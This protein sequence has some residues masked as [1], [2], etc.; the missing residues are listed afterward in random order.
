[1]NI[2]EI[3]SETLY[4]E[5]SLEIPYDEIDDLINT[6]IKEIIPTVSL[7]GFRK[8]KA[9]I[10]IVKKKY[11]S[12][13]LSDVIEKIVQEKTKNLLEEKKLKPFRQPRVDLK[14]YEKNQPVQIEVKIDLEPKI[15]LKNFKNLKLKKYKIE[16][17]KKT[18]E[19]NYN[20][21]LSS[22]KNYNKLE[23]KRVVKISDKININIETKDSTVPE[24]LKSQKNFPLVTDSEYQVLPELGK[25]LI[26]KKVKTGDKIVLNFDISKIINSKTAKKVDFEIEVL[27]IEESIPFKITDE[28]LK[29]HGFTSENELKESLEKNILSQYQNGIQQ[30]EK[31]QLMDILDSEHNFEL[32]NGILDEEFQAIWHRL[33]HAKKDNT[34]DQDDKNL[35]DDELKKRYKKISKRRVKLAILLQQIAKN[36]DL[37]VSEKELTDGMIN[38]ASKYPGQE[39][40]ILDYFKKNPS[41]IESIKGPILEQKVIDNITSKS[42]FSEIKLSIKEYIKLEEKTFKINNKE[43]K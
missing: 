15:V 17:D 19:D 35:T 25:K 36:E 8:G 10:S 1:M 41:S 40:Q 20:Q 14:K 43:K 24:F 32:P 28:Y 16:L 12:N 38:Y 18:I 3:K 11:E 37:S 13:V 9:P 5:Y 26:E 6:K 33:E 22:Q 23:S 34:L 4:K 21:F 42:K 7:P 2:K 31:K 29:K 30:I 39:K 27:S